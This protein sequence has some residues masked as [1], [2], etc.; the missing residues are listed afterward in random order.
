M[1]KQISRALSDTCSSGH[2]PW[3]LELRATTRLHPTPAP[4]QPRWV[5]VH[6][7]T[8]PSGWD[9]ILALPWA[10]AK[11]PHLNGEMGYQLLSHKAASPRSWQPPLL[12]P[13]RLPLPFLPHKGTSPK[14]NRECNGQHLWNL[15]HGPGRNSQRWRNCLPHPPH[16][17]H[18]LSLLALLQVATGIPK[19]PQ[20]RPLPPRG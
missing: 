17:P 16:Q 11:W 14:V 19:K 4:P 6:I 15:T 10:S 2:L 13:P 5:R 9:S 12:P 1:E 8:E 7:L 3:W 20:T 18:F